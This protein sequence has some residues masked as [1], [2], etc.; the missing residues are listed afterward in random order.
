MISLLSKGIKS[1]R[2]HHSS[3]ASILWLL[4]LFIV[5]LSHPYT[6]TGNTILSLFICSCCISNPWQPPVAVLCCAQSLQSCLAV[7]NPMDCS[8]PGP[9]V[10]RILQARILGCCCAGIQMFLSSSKSSRK[11]QHKNNRERGRLLCI[12]HFPASWL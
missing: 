3:K 9:S 5:Q 6:T 11:R 8:P 12:W 7:C 1:L 2:Q 10:H 4:A